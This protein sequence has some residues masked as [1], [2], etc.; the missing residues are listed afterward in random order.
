MLKTPHTLKPP[1]SITTY[2][3]NSTKNITLVPLP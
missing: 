2:A 1:T 3:L